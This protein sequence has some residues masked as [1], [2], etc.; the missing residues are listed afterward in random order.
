MGFM[1]GTKEGQY[2]ILVGHRWQQDR[3]DIHHPESPTFVKT[4]TN[5]FL[6]KNTIFQSLLLEKSN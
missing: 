5:R 3:P 4:Y 2:G 6:W 1:G